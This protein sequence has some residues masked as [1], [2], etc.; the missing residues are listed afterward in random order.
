MALKNNLCKAAFLAATGTAALLVTE[1][2]AFELG[3]ADADIY[4]ASGHEALAEELSGYLVK[5]F[6]SRSR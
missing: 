3:A 1:A 2:H 5:V 6:G 4:A